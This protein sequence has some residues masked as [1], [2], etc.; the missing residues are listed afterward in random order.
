MAL[1]EPYG[2]AGAR[3]T[4]TAP[5]TLR[6]EDL[7]TALISVVAAGGQVMAP[8][9]TSLVEAAPPSTT[10]TR[11]PQRA[12]TRAQASVPRRGPWRSE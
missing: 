5:A 8:H 2:A 3:L 1:G 6:H 11:S 12:L 4:A 9:G 10:R 7:N